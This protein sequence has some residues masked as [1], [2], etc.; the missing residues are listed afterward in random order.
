MQVHLHN[1]LVVKA[2][3]NKI[4]NTNF[5]YPIDLVFRNETSLI[6]L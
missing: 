3:I 2:V 6:P 4:I 5:K 1:L